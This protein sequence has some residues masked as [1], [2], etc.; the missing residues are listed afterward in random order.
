MSGAVD[1]ATAA[2]VVVERMVPGGAGLGRTAD[3]RIRLVAGG[4]PGDR[5]RPREGDRGDDALTVRAF[6]IVERGADRVEPECPWADRCGGCDWM[7]LERAAEL[8][9]KRAVVRDALVRVG[10]LQAPPVEAVRTAGASIA[11]RDRLRLHVSDAGAVGLLG[12]R[13][14]AVV[15]IDRC[16]VARPELNAAIGELRAAGRRYAG[17]LAGIEELELRVA[18]AGPPVAL[19]ARLREPTQLATVALLRELARRWAVGIGT[20]GRG[21]GGPARVRLPQPEDQRWPLPGG[22]TLS[23][24]P[25]AFTQPSREVAA[26]LVGAV[27]AGARQRGVRTF[28]DLYCGAGAFTLALG[29]T[30]ASGVG[31][32]RDGSALRAAERQRRAAG[33][34]GVRFVRGDAASLVDRVGEPG[35]RPDLVVV[36]PPRAGAR[37]AVEGLLRLRPAHVAMCSCDPATLARDLGALVAGGYA[38]EEIVPFDMFPRTHHVET[39][40]WLR[41][42]DAGGPRAG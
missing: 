28:V 12:A 16:L 30:G 11:L 7:H 17:A 14:R 29:A 38:L 5:L 37:G 8:R 33:A 13:S 23:A 19:A 34:S 3:G 27:V 41:V 36:D 39:L 35:E 18:P 42:A 20:R 6:E 32:E 31:V 26:L 24:P 1:T 22:A 21:P 10:R 15:E 2:D 4:A 9:E 40:A 25:D